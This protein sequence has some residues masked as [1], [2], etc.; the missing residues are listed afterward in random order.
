LRK[1]PPDRHA[2]P[3]EK[4]FRTLIKARYPDL[5]TKPAKG[6]PIVTVLFDPHGAIL[7]SE[8]EISSEPSS[9]LAASESSF[10]R[11]GAAARDLQYIGAASIHVPA[12]TVLVVFA[13]V[14]SMDV[15]RALVQR[16]FPQVFQE[17]STLSQGIW[18][19]F[20]HDGRVLHTGQEHFKPER[21]RQTL[22]KRYPGIRTSD[23]TETPV[24]GQDGRPIRDLQGQPL[25]LSCVWL[26]VG[27]P[28]PQS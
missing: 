17:G 19:L 2:R 9:E 1:P 13:G 20:D 7:R 22:E 16:F 18:I 10:S 23:V 5:L 27:S 3:Y 14:G 26:A 6:T 8:L 12:N 21:L 25:Q 11:Y 28:L 15:D 24:I 4:R